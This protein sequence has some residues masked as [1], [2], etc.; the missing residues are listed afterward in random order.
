MIIAILYQSICLPITTTYSNSIYASRGDE[1]LEIEKDRKGAHQAEEE[2]E[3]RGMKQVADC[4][5]R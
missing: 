4:Q 2:K 1:K 5:F 3:E